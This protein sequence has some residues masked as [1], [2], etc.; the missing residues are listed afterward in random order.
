MAGGP[1]S[2]VVD[3]LSALG[4]F[5]YL[6]LFLLFIVMY[7]AFYYL[8]REKVK[9][10]KNDSYR[11]F[12]SLMLSVLV[13]LGAYM[14]VFAYAGDA[15]TVIAAALFAIFAI[16]FVLVLVGK[17]AGIDLPGMLRDEFR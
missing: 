1:F 10:L 14:S 17:M 12:I 9:R 7:F 4:A 15:V 16:F 13:T 11:K 3:Y 2:S 5:N 8:F 6:A